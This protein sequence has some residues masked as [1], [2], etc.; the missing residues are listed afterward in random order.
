MTT[1]FRALCADL[2][3]AITD[4]SNGCCEREDDVMDRARAALATP[5][6]E[7]QKVMIPDQYKVRLH[8]ND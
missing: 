2:I 7:A 4:D 5:S 3:K 1:D 8:S 6:P